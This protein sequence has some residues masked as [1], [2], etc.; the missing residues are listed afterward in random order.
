MQVPASTIS[1]GRSTGASPGDGPPSVGVS[2]RI[3]MPGAGIPSADV[4]IPSPTPDGGVGAAPPGTPGGGEV[5]RGGSPEAGE[6]G[7]AGGTP[8]HRSSPVP[9]RARTDIDSPVQRIDGRRAIGSSCDR[10]PP[11]GHAKP[12]QRLTG[13]ST[14][15]PPGE[16]RPDAGHN[17]GG[18]GATARAVPGRLE[19]ASPQG[20][21]A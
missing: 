7:G 18:D 19:C 15:V 9:T 16:T 8:F 10:A 3:S 21:R 6:C 11:R 4:T 13:D 12:I 20:G 2:P 17:E 14:T 5:R 1:E